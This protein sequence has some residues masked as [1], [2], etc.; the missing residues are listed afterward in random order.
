MRLQGGTTHSSGPDHAHVRRRNLLSHAT[1][2]RGCAPAELENLARYA[3]VRICASETVLVSQETPADAVYFVAY[4]RVRLTLLGESDRE[5]TVAELGQGDCF[6]EAAILEGA[7]YATTAIATDEV[8]VL[9]I[10]RAAFL[11]C[12]RAHPSIGLRLA[13]ELTRRLDTVSQQLAE[14][15]MQDVESRVA[16]ALRRMAKRDGQPIRGGVVIPRRVTHQQIANLVGTT[17][18]TVSRSVSALTRR[19]LVS[20]RDGLFV[21]TPAMLAAP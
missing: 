12:L 7:H 19:G 15:V 2:L 17:R 1:L 10:E 14:L 13:L 18:E 9:V 11:G 3:Q 20:S 16:L 8:M 6:G 4:G 5:L 21:L